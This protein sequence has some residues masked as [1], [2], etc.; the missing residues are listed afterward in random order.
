MRSIQK[1]TFIT[2][3]LFTGIFTGK[4]QTYVLIPDP[5]FATYLKGLIPS[6]IKG[7]SLNIASTLVTTETQSINV[8][9]Q[10]IKD[11]SGIQY[12]TS[13]TWL[14]CSQSGLT[15]LAA[16]P[17]SLRFLDCGSN[18]LS[19][20][21]ALPNSLTTLNCYFNFLSDLP[22]LPASLINL[23]CQFNSITNLP[24]LPGA[25]DM[26]QCQYNQIASFPPFP[27]SLTY[28]DCSSNPYTCLPNYVLPVMKS[29]TTTP[30]CGK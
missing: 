22:A 23:N 20:L 16:L 15:K 21:P 13:L 18:N 6:A 5:N 30:L 27:N 24:A 9:G 26:L 4:S 11:L 14:D 25:L 28:M 19:T 2:L 12:F 29:F 7:N 10:N 1:I 8:S 3:L 17:N